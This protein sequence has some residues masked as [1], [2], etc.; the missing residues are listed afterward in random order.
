VRFTR[1]AGERIGR[2][3][4]GFERQTKG[5]SPLTFE[6]QTPSVPAN[7]KVFRAATFTGA[8]GIESVKVVNVRSGGTLAVENFIASFP[9]SG[10]KK[11]G[12]AKD[13]TGWFLVCVQHVS[14]DVVYDVVQT[15]TSLRF[16]RIRIWVPAKV[17]TAPA[18]IS[19][20]ECVT[21]YTG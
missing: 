16:D 13:G 2:A 10:T 5:A 21:G 17:T 8:W 20:A 11:I 3:V 18:I 14:Q 12:V 7:S 4:V 15:S 6:H 9:D 1:G 19:L